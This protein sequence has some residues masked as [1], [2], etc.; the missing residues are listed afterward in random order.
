MVF[1][2]KLVE[3]DKLDTKEL[4]KRPPVVT[5]MGH[6]DHGKTTL[7]D[8]YRDS[9]ITAGEVGGITQKVGGFMVETKLG[10]VTFIDTPGHAVFKN[11]RQRG[12]DCTDMVV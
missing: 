10:N 7:L 9:T 3:N 2:Y 8:A 11:M 4:Q 5:I 1:G 6:V 12:A